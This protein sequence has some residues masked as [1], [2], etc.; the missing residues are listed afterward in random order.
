ML[1]P[2]TFLPLLNKA[3]GL[4]AVFDLQCMA[5]QSQVSS[6]TGVLFNLNAHLGKKDVL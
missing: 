3:K 2:L 6:P 5:L 1:M 4:N